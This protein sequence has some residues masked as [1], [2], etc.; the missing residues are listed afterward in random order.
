MDARTI[1]AR[2]ADHYSFQAQAAGERVVEIFNE[3]SDWWGYGLSLL[4]EDLGGY[5]GPVRVK[6]N[7]VGGDYLEGVA[8]MNYLKEFA[9]TVEVIG[10]AASS[11]TIIASAGRWVQIHEGAFY[12]IHNPMTNWG[13]NANELEADLSILR[14]MEAD[15]RSVYAAGIRRRGKM[16]QL[17]DAE[18]DAKVKE[19]MDT[20]TW[21]TAAEAVE[22]G[23]ADELLKSETGRKNVEAAAKTRYFAQA[24]FK[25]APALD[26]NKKTDMSKNTL[27]GFLDGLKNLISQTE[28]ELPAAE[29]ATAAAEETPA[30]VDAATEAE[31]TAAIQLLTDLGYSVEAPE[32]EVVVEPTPV[33]EAKKDKEP[34]MTAAEVEALVTARV[35]AAMKAAQ[36]AKAVTKTATAPA[37]AVTKREELAAEAAKALNSLTKKMTK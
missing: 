25:N 18:L 7:S 24:N 37:K 35:E 14:K 26:I 23:F 3:I 10:L 30:Q 15:M 6:V 22:Y 36:A 20:E 4:R 13:G 17:T 1:L 34:I 29:T 16:E 19:W 8:I 11:A 21:F 33:E 9:P 32:E 2:K 31:I 28:V 12:M 5:K 27:T